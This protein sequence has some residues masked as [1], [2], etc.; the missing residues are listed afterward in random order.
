MCKKWTLSRCGREKNA[1]QTGTGPAYGVGWGQKKPS[2]APSSRG[3]RR[4]KRLQGLNVR[5]KVY[6]A[7]TRNLLSLDVHNLNS[8]TAS[9]RYPDMGYNARSGLAISQDRPESSPQETNFGA[10]GTLLCPSSLPLLG[11]QGEIIYCYCG[12][13]ILSWLQTSESLLA[14]SQWP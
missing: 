9:S 12:L 4:E 14:K 5:S 11:Y 1:P 13:H 6:R 3:I 8:S 7:A 2:G 10:F